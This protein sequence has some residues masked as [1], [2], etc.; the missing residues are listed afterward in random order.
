MT[1]TESNE[2]PGVADASEHGSES[3]TP[4]LTRSLR[5]V[6]RLMRTEVQR[7]LGREHPPTRGEVKQAIRSIEERAADAVPA[8]DLAVTIATLDRIAEAFGG[9]DALPFRPFHPGHRGHRGGWAGWSHRF[10]PE[11]P[12]DR[13]W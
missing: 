1:T 7:S 10:H 13:R 5:L 2:Q 4:N 3:R 8:A 6:S 9:R 11:H 12:G